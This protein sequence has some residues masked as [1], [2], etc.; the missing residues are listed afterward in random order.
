MKPLLKE[1]WVNHGERLVF[2]FLAL[3]FSVGM[4]LIGWVDEAKVIIIGLAMLC[5]NKARSGMA[6]KST[7]IKEEN[8]KATNV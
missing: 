2:M 7:L 6:D 4:Y 8:E 5:Y 1:F 3:A